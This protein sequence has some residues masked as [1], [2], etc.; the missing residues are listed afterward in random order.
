LTIFRKDETNVNPGKMSGI[1]KKNIKQNKQSASQRIPLNKEY[2]SN[3]IL[4]WAPLFILV[5]T[6]LIYRKAIFNGFA[7]WDDNYYIQENPFI[8]DFSINR[9]KAIFSSFYFSNYHPLTTLTY[10][11][12]FKCFGLNPLPFHILNVALHL[13]NTWLVF[14]LAERLSGKKIT[15]ILVSLLFAIHPM[16]VESVAWISERKDLLYTTFYLLS[17]MLYLRYLEFKKAK[18]YIGAV[19]L[20]IFSLLSK[21]AAVTLPVLLIAIDFYKGRKINAKLLLEKVPFF[22]LALLFGII[23]IMSQLTIETNADIPLPNGFIERIFLCSYAIAFYIIKMVAPF[24]LSA[25]YYFSNSQ[26]GSLTWAYYASL[27]FLLIIVWLVIRNR[28]KLKEII[29]G[30]F[31]FLITISVM[32]Q[33]VHVGSAITADRY[34]Y[35][36]YIGL[37]FIAVQSIINIKKKQVKNTI[38]TLFCVFIIMFSFQTYARIK[39]WKDGD[40]LFTDV[41]KKNPNIFHA[42]WIRGQAKKAKGD[43]QGSLQDFTKALELKPD[44]VF[45]LIDRGNVR[46]DM[47]D[48]KGALDD[49][50]HAVMLDPAMAKAYN[51]R[52]I[53]HVL[54]GDKK[55]AMLDY[56]KAI[57]L[58][59]EFAEAFNNRASL[60]A[61]T[62]D[63]KGAINDVNNAILL[64]PYKAEYYRDRGEIRYLKNDFKDAINDFNYSLKLKPDDYSCYY[65]SGMSK[66]NLKDTSGACKDWEKSMKLGCTEASE[67]I[68]KYCH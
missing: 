34:T 9:I 29:F 55:S 13:L 52:G 10:L 64:T 62:G 2:S 58:N 18:F 31:F 22:I 44:F 35:V 54:L 30:I 48:Y 27:P 28:S 57:K 39:V 40:V 23:A 20:F 37:F 26:N 59:P 36:S 21:S 51:N 41:I 68:T 8:R 15:G 60:K 56:D 12:E 33:I 3:G 67:A 25:M 4:K 7:T 19:L 1:Q 53:V 63:L 49:Y 16:H 24:N 50:N 32:L 66:L 17:L 38:I 65:F 45:G 43:L 46:S 61:N 11:I 47:G 42:Y 6:A 5:F 14:I